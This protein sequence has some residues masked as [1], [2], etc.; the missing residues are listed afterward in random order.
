MA[1]GRTK[2]GRRQRAE[3]AHDEQEAVG[4]DQELES[5]LAALAPEEDVE[6]TGSGRGFGAAQVYQ[7]RLP[8]MAN[9]RL[10]ELAAQQGTSPDA[11][12]RDWVMQHLADADAAVPE[13]PADDARG[14]QQEGLPDGGGDAETRHV[15]PQHRQPHAPQAARAQAGPPQAQGAPAQPPRAQPPRPQEPG[16]AVD[17]R[18]AAAQRGGPQQ[19]AGQLYPD[20]APP[21]PVDQVP[22]EQFPAD[23]YHVEETDTEIT[24]PGNQYRY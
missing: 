22:A 11:L 12:A 20:D 18:Q 6:T 3:P 1:L 15:Q 13:W 7:L 21:Y 24:I 16:P 23:P 10:K 8:L 19:Y 9:E 5:Y 17:P 2:I 4:P 14:T